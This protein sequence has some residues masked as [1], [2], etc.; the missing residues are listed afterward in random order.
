LL[1]SQSLWPLLLVITANK[2]VD[3]IRQNNRQ[4]PRRWPA[5]TFRRR[6]RRDS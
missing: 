5:T 1:D 6:S 3:L 4:R 2:S